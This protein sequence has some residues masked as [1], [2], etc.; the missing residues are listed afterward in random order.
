MTCSESHSQQA[1]EL[2]LEPN[3]EM[4]Q[5]CALLWWGPRREKN[6]GERE[7][8]DNLMEKEDEEKEKELEEKRG[9][10]RGRRRRQKKDQWR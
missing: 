1:V 2:G 3:S 4:P 6:G 9:Q 8:Q 5:I 10:Y 7:E